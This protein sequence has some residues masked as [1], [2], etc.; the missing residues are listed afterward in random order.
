MPNRTNILLMTATITPP[1]GVSARSDPAIRLIDYERALS[2]YL[3]QIG[4][5]LDRIVFIE[6]SGSD[7]SSL[8]LLSHEAGLADCCEF[9]AFAGLDYPPAYGYGFGE[10]KLL[11]YGMAEA[12][13]VRESGPESIIA[14][15]TGRYIVKNLTRLL[16][17]PSQQFDVLCDIR[18]RR[19]PWADMR[20]MC[21]TR[22]GYE[23]VLKGVH[24]KLRDDINRVPPEMVLSRHLLEAESR[25]NIRT[26]FPFELHVQGV[27]GYDNRNWTGGTYLVKHYLR[28]IARRLLCR[29]PI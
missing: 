2:F 29:Y 12:R 28:A 24:V 7:V 9:I 19:R 20:V 6:N 11:D 8:H 4:R 15:V 1:P 10:F 18:N 13:T 16:K 23:A 3:G 26:R 25:A 14:K 27:R 17:E 21:W 5:G 22:L